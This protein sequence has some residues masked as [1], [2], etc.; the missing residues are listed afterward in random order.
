MLK[1]TLNLRLTK[2]TIISRRNNCLGGLN[3]K[4]VMFSFT[5]PR[6]GGYIGGV[7]AVINSYREKAS[8]FAEQNY[9]VDV[10]DFCGLV[11][12]KIRNPIFRKVLYGVEQRRSAVLAIK[13]NDVD[14]F[15]IHTSRNS[16]FLKDILLGTYVKK[17]TKAKVVLSIHVGNINTVFEKIMPFKSKMIRYMNIYFDKVIFLS[18]EMREQ[19]IVAGLDGNRCELLYNF[20]N[21]API[22]EK[23]KLSRS[24]MLHL[25]YVGAIHREKGIM[26][27]LAALTNM[28]DVDFH[29]D[30]CGQITDET[31]A[32]DF[33]QMVEQ[34]ENKIT[35]WGYVS[36]V[37]KTALFERADA[38][39][40]PS[41]HEGLPL[42]ILEG[43]CQGC[44]LVSTKVG[45]IP[46]ILSEQN[47]LWV[48]AGSTESIENAVRR[49]YSDATLMLNI[50]S[51][52]KTLGLEYG[53]KNHIRRLCCIYSEI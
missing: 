6:R 4:R 30:I 45:S 36:G 31:I 32:L 37:Q 46:E 34:L 38:L 13:R 47:V 42:V 25:L 52:N 48:D 49:L 14:I 19:F 1:E 17:R 12:D 21:M 28:K 43:L 24:A 40:L 11:S 27:L 20:H 44:A 50:Q 7:A 16:L 39:L 33:Q 2:K 10:F 29:L 8:L 15:H 5:M 3:L 26:D 53:I 41:Y 22:A 18:D 35:L 23:E 9:C 51:K